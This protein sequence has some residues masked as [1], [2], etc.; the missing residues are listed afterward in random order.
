MI[1]DNRTSSP[2]DFFSDDFSVTLTEESFLQ[3]IFVLTELYG[4]KCVMD[5]MP[6]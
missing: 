2:R 1:H 5:M 4:L 6:S 3:E